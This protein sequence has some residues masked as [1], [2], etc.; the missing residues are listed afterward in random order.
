MSRRT[1]CHLHFVQNTAVRQEVLNDRTCNSVYTKTGSIKFNGLPGN[2]CIDNISL[3][4]GIR[5]VD[6][7]QIL[8]IGSIRQFNA[9]INRSTICRLVLHIVIILINNADIKQPDV[10]RAAFFHP[11]CIFSL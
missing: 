5:K 11:Q 9:H 3:I 10:S 4:V 8:R 7:I 6:N 1:I 2:V